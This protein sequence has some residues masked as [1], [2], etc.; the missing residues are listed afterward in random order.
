VQQA[1][2]SAW[3]CSLGCCRA[4]SAWQH[5][6]DTRWVTFFNKWWFC[7]VSEPW[8][9]C[10]QLS[11]ASKESRSSK[12]VV[13]RCARVIWASKPLE[14]Q[15]RREHGAGAAAAAG[16]TAETPSEGMISM[17]YVAMCPQRLISISDTCGWIAKML[18]S[19]VC[20][21][22]NAGAFV[23]CLHNEHLPRSAIPERMPLAMEELLAP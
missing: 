1:G 19:A 9:R 10:Q 20:C 5:G 2:T 11:A 12:S 22:V 7:E 15:A 21:S 18:A 3:G 4:A 16:G 14:Q 8:L 13:L 23:Y 17:S 6:R